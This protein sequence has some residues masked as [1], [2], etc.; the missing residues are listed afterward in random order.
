MYRNFVNDQTPLADPWRS[1]G[2][3]RIGFSA[4]GL[5]LKCDGDGAGCGVM[6]QLPMRYADY[7][8]RMMTS[9]P[10]DRVTTK[11]N[12]LLWPDGGRPWPPEIDFN[13]SGDRLISHQTIHWGNFDENF[14][15]HS[16]YPV[17]QTVLHTYRVQMWPDAIVYMLDGRVTRVIPE[18]EGLPDPAQ[19]FNLHVRAEPNNAPLD[20]TTLTVNAITIRALTGRYFQG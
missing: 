14:M 18:F 15:L 20:K 12:A 19:L 13:E 6:Y 5:E 10:L 9:G 7:K 11:H 8:V 16:K 1:W 4:F 17:N 2:N 3:A